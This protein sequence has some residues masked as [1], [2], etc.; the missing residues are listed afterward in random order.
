MTRHDTQIRFTLDGQLFTT[1]DDDQEAAALLRLVGH[2][3]SGFDL[4]RIDD[5]GDET[6][7]LDTDI[8]RVHP[9]DSFITRPTLHFTIDGVP[10]TT[11]DDDQEVAALLRLAGVNPANHYLA[12][13]GEPTHLDPGELVKIHPGDSFVTVRHDSPVA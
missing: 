9:G 1:I 12:R 8:V 10:Y 2:D 7:F 3:P 4:G 13:V 6:F 5:E 11:H